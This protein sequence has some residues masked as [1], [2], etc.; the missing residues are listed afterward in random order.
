MVKWIL[1]EKNVI[2]INAQN[3]KLAKYSMWLLKFQELNLDSIWLW[4]FI[5][6]FQNWAMLTLKIS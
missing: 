5:N 2:I 1:C 6:Y 3:K 4:H